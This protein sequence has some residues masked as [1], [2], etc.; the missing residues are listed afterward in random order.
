[1]NFVT[2]WRLRLRGVDGPG[3]WPIGELLHPG[4]LCALLALLVNDWI[5]KRGGHGGW[6]GGKVSDFSGAVLAPLVLTSVIGCS[7]KLLQRGGLAITASLSYRRLHGAL[8]VVAIAILAAK[9]SG[10]TNHLVQAAWSHL[11][12]TARVAFDRTDLLALPALLLAWQIG[13]DELRRG[14]L[15]AT[16]DLLVI[17][18][19]LVRLLKLRARIPQ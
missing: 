12:P 6:V 4:T 14:P 2:A 7:R 1:M 18:L 9:G 19:R 10:L 16:D 11:L 3:R 5:I 15:G 8:A 17:R 13:R